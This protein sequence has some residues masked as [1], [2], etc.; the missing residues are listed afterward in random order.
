[1]SIKGDDPKID[2]KK[3]ES[4]YQN[5]NLESVLYSEEELKK[6]YLLFKSKSKT[7]SHYLGIRY[8]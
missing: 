7:A 8:C 1:M 6:Y 2:E 3:W 5:S 4:I